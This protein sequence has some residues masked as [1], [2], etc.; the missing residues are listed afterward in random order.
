MEQ[1]KMCWLL[2]FLIARLCTVNIESQKWPIRIGRGGGL[3]R[4]QL[5]KK[6]KISLGIGHDRYCLQRE[7]GVYVVYKYPH[8][9]SML[10]IYY[11]NKNN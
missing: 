6:C 2:F 5:Y 11:Y 8:I 10:G 3:N 1:I 7:C 4:D 9:A